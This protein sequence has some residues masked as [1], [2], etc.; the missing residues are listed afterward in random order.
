MA[1]YKIHHAKDFRQGTDLGYARDRDAVT[2]ALGRGD[3]E[4]AGEVETDN[5]EDAYRLSQNDFG[6]WSQNGRRSTSVGDIIEDP[7]GLAYMVAP[8]GFLGLIE[9]PS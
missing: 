2:L 3:Y 6:T 1:T 5:I 8:T 7:L 9:V 4:V